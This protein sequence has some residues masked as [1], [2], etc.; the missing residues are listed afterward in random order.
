[1]LMTQ[2]IDPDG[3]R[4]FVQPRDWLAVVTH[5]EKQQAD[6]QKKLLPWLEHVDCKGNFVVEPHVRQPLTELYN[7][8][9]SASYAGG[10]GEWLG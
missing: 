5:E 7:R 8:R 4:S 10:R 1:M 6:V 2:C 3:E 9:T